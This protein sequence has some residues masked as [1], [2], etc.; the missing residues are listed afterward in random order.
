MRAGKLSASDIEGA[1]AA[2]R[3]VVETHRRL[4]AWLRHGMTCAQIDQYVAQTLADLKC[5]SCFLHYTGAERHPPFPSHACLS[6][7]DCVVHGTATSHSAPLAAGDVLKID[8]GVKH[9]G[10]IGDAAWTYCFGEPSPEVARLMSCGKESLRR[11]IARLSPRATWMDWA[12]EVQGYVEGECGFHLIDGL[13]GHGYG[14]SLHASPFVSNVVPRVKPWQ[15]MAMVWSDG[16]QRCE[17]GT[18]VALEPMISVGTAETYQRKNPYN[19]RLMDWPVYTA[20][21]SMSVH[22]EHDVLITDDGCIVLTEGL[23]DTPDVVTA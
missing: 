16:P 20:D 14:R 8:I 12:R 18:L 19:P 6:V 21:G 10:W 3:C 1:R 17:P 13:G 9:G 23:E 15:T 22:Y 5:R 7:N 4:A 2:A 11:G